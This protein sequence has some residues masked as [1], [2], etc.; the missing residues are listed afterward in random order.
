MTSPV[1][2]QTARPEHRHLMKKRSKLCTFWS[3]SQDRWVLRGKA[4]CSF[5]ISPVQVTNFGLVPYPELPSWV[6][7]HISPNIYFCRWLLACTP[8][9][10]IRARRVGAAFMSPSDW[11]GASISF[12]SLV[13]YLGWQ[14]HLRQFTLLVR[15]RILFPLS[16]CFIY[17]SYCVKSH[18]L[19]LS[20]KKLILFIYLDLFL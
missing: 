12:P 17:F 6:P 7:Q 8:E 20:F 18:I 4:Q 1:K 3:S 2:S 10:F 5:Q 9:H 11:P 13:G 19:W 16:C 14:P 15:N